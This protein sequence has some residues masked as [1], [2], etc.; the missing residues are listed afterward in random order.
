[1]TA[2]MPVTVL[3]GCLCL[4][5][6]AGTAALDGRF[7][8][9]LGAP[10]VAPLQRPGEHLFSVKDPTV[11]HYDGRW[12]LFCS[13]RGRERSHQIEYITFTD[14]ADT[15]SAERHILTIS[16]GYFCAPQVFYFRPHERWY[17]VLQVIDK[18]RK[19]A[20][21]PAVSTTDD[22]ADPASWSEPTL[23]FD[24]HPENVEM[25][26]DFWVIC[27]EE[28]A[29]LFFTSLNGRMWR[30]QTPLADFPRGWGRP[31]VVLQADVFEASH[32][33][34]LQGTDRYL[35]VIEAEAHP[36][37]YYKAYVADRLDGEWRPLADT[38]EQPFASPVNVTDQGEHWTDSISH[39]EMLRAGYDERLE[40]D[41]AN[42][43][44]LFQGA[45]EEEMGGRP[46][47]QIPWR[48]GLLEPRR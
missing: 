5:A 12:H 9:T 27:D 11:V 22:I 1:M 48:L 20:L 6:A 45:L 8:W 47:G 39:G 29:H 15:A 26:I 32:T 7:E 18:S 14:W 33:Y 36:R 37:R 10:L 34:K 28:N 30:A 4:A 38:S 35:T 25:W 44:F 46:Y 40:I 31:E 41:P 43:R 3:L 16:D 2:A 19:P 23:L 24:E 13:I 17:M 42:L 21:Q